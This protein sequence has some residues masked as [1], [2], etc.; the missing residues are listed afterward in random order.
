M[1]NLIIP[2]V[3][4][5]CILLGNGFSNKGPGDGMGI[6]TWETFWNIRRHHVLL[7]HQKIRLWCPV[8]PPITIVHLK[9]CIGVVC[10]SDMNAADDMLLICRSC[11]EILLQIKPFIFQTFAQ[12][13]MSHWRRNSKWPRNIDITHTI[14]AYIVVPLIR[15]NRMRG[16]LQYAR[17]EAP[18]KTG[19]SFSANIPYWIIRS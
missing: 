5:S 4:F 17:K 7:T 13:F 18:S 12:T 16:S 10:F 8:I 11:L 6:N 1:V 3:R 14:I 2:L 19:G 15:K 9:Q